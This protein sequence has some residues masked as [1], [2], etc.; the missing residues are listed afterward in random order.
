M[1]ACVSLPGIDCLALQ[2]YGFPFFF[3]ITMT[4][5]AG[6]DRSLVDISVMLK[7]FNW[8]QGPADMYV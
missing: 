2:V 4:E 6:N 7:H 1:M 8:K 3:H 5:I